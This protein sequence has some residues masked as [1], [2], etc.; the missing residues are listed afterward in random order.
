MSRVSESL[1]SF[2]Q[3]PYHAKGAAINELAVHDRTWLTGCGTNLFTGER[4]ETARE[5]VADPA[6]AARRKAVI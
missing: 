6:P 3:P 4:R 1:A 5:T 2:E